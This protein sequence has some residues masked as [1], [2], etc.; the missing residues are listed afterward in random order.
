MSVLPEI[1]AGSLRSGPQKVRMLPSMLPR[2]WL[3]EKTETN[4]DPTLPEPDTSWVTQEKT[5]CEAARAK[6]L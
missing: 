5:Q 3:Q 2:T 1:A 6:A 4:D